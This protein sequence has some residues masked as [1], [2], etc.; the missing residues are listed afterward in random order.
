[1]LLQ[2][3]G[4]RVHVSCRHSWNV[5][6]TKSLSNLLPIK[7]LINAKSGDKVDV[8]KLPARNSR[9]RPFNQL[10]ASESASQ[11]VTIKPTITSKC[12]PS[13]PQQSSCFIFSINAT[14]FEGAPKEAAAA[15]PR[16]FMDDN[17][18]TAR[19]IQHFC[20]FTARN[21]TNSNVLI[22]LTPN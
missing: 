11:N 17:S 15:A 1:M 2:Q 7:R 3:N 14:V 20:S 19:N 18:T 8:W 21:L 16:I 22:T 6:N 9:R 4:C 12:S 10:A 13:S 5:K